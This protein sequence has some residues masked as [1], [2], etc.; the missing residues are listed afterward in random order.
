MF[1][2]QTLWRIR[3][4]SL[5]LIHWGNVNIFKFAPHLTMNIFIYRRRN[6]VTLIFLLE[7]SWILLGCHQPRPR[8][9]PWPPPPITLWPLHHHYYSPSPCCHH[10]HSHSCCPPFPLGSTVP[11][12][13][14]GPRGP[15][16]GD[17]SN[18]HPSA[19]P[20]PFTHP[21]GLWWT[22]SPPP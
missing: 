4:I 6:M 22:P 9:R 7:N 13:W 19:P 21:Q 17:N 5:K 8:P 3:F 16:H 14:R 12:E 18:C 1:N 10:S 15:K 2:T 20:H 11:G